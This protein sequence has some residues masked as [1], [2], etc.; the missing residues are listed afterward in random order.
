[1]FVAEG[2]GGQVLHAEPRLEP[3]LAAIQLQRVIRE[4]D[5]IIPTGRSSS[6]RKETTGSVIPRAVFAITTPDETHIVPFVE[7]VYFVVLKPE[8]CVTI[9]GESAGLESLFKVERFD[10]AVKIAIVAVPALER[11]IIAAHRESTDRELGPV[12]KWLGLVGRCG[13]LDLGRSGISHGRTHRRETDEDQ[14]GSC[15]LATATAS[16]KGLF[17]ND[18]VVDVL[19]KY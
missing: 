16:E 11:G 19:L 4:G 1:M 3:Q 5:G 6:A 13:G 17:H 7:E 2:D 12:F 9:H 8:Q 18:E 14:C 15:E 10:T